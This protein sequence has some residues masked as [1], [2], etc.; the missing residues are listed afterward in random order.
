MGFPPESCLESSTKLDSKPMETN[1][2]QKNHPLKV[3]VCLSIEPTLSSP[4]AGISKNENITEAMMKP[5]MNF[6]N[7]FHISIRLGF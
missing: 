5:K 4:I 3:F 2:R 7:L 1:A 6:G